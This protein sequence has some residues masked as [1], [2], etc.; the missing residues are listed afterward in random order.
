MSWLRVRHLQQVKSEVAA[1]TSPQALL[2]KADAAKI[3]AV[4][5]RTLDRMRVSGEIE[6]VFVRSSVRIPAAAV[7]RYIVGQLGSAAEVEAPADPF[8]IPLLDDLKSEAVERK[9]KKLKAA[10]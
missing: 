4:S 2:T 9:A 7:E 5:V 1:N 3:L 6:T 8:A 10:A